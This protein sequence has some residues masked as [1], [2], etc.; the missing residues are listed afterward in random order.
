MA[1]TASVTKITHP[2]AVQ[3]LKQQKEYESKRV[4]NFLT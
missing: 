1:A 3:K 4:L 2:G